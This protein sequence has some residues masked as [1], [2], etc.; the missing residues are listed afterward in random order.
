MNRLACLAPLF[1]L[2]AQTI[3]CTSN[4]DDESSDETAAE[5]QDL[6][7]DSVLQGAERQ[8]FMDSARAEFFKAVDRTDPGVSF[9]VEQLKIAPGNDGSPYAFMVARPVKPGTA[10]DYDYR[11][12]PIQA[13][14]DEGLFDGNRAYVVQKKVNGK[15]TMLQMWLGPTDVAWAGMPCSD[16]APA[17]IF[18]MSPQSCDDYTGWAGKFMVASTNG[19]VV[20]DFKSEHP[21]VFD[22]EIQQGND[23]VVAKGLTATFTSDQDVA[24]VDVV[25]FRKGD[26]HLRM[27]KGFEFGSATLEVTQTGACTSLGFNGA[28]I[29][30]EYYR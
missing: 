4:G 17:S 26:C 25:T 3:A 8:Q 7:G 29:S 11:G 20:I 13:V 2:L 1:L 30:A 18:G 12:T 24:W 28:D 16:G 21:L 9:L 27:E 19:G 14:I 5:A 10:I 22:L 15:W 6:V 23:F